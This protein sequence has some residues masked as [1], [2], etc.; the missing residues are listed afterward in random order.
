MLKPRPFSFIDHECGREYTRDQEGTLW[1]LKVH[2]A[3]AL[4][5]AGECAG[6]R[7]GA[8]APFIASPVRRPPTA[9]CHQQAE[10]Q[11]GTQA[12]P[13]AA[14]TPGSL[15]APELSLLPLLGVL[16]QEVFIHWANS[17]FPRSSTCHLLSGAC[18]GPHSRAGHPILHR[19]MA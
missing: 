9:P 1:Y 14:S 4:A 19:L 11:P 18:P 10:V 3:P 16:C 12:L 7:Q 2:R 13:R 5:W 8:W 17:S 6:E 15:T